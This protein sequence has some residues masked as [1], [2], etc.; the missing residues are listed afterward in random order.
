MYSDINDNTISK[1]QNTD[2]TGCDIIA[3]KCK[4]SEQSEIE[5]VKN[6]LSKILPHINLP[7]MICGCD[8][9]EIDCKLL[10][11]IIKIL[12]RQCIISYATE[13][14]YKKIIPHIIKGN[15]YV[16]LKTPI[17]INLA[18]ELNILSVE[19]GLKKEK[20]IM[21]TDIGG[22]GYG[23]EYGYSIMEKIRL[24]GEKGDEYLDLPL[25]SE[26]SSEALKTKEA[27]TSDT[28]G[29]RMIELCAA[30]GVIAAGANIITVSYP[31]NIKILRGLI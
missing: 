25:I 28:Q 10:P 31:Q 9:D 5:T 8:K 17:D 13:Q 15:H 29:T 4:I 24:E 3:L 30:S 27:K 14:T 19:M 21:N 22:L 2:L 6:Q 23:Y 16:V 18:K 26:A 20:I 7:L 11:E 12:D 1:L